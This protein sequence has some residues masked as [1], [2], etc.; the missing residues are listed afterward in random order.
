VSTDPLKRLFESADTTRG[1]SER[2]I[3]Q[4]VEHTQLLQRA[5]D[6]ARDVPFWREHQRLWRRAALISSAAVLA[7]GGA[8]TAIT[9]LRSPVTNT[10]QM[11]C[12]SQDSVHSRVIS[13]MPYSVHPL[14]A[15]KA[16]LH[17]R[18]VPSSKT[19]AGLLCVLPDGSLGGFPPS[20]KYET[21]TS[22]GLTAFNGKL[23]YPHV[24][25]F[26]KAAHSFFE[27]HACSNVALAR[28]RMLELIG[29]YALRGWT[30]QVSGSKVPTACATFDT[31]SARRI[32]DVV[33]VIE[34][35]K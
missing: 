20:K 27:I 11:S 22:I 23:K 5:Q 19:S 9:L 33:A 2:A 26:E 18:S 4:L 30:V 8:A 17:W 1:M 6:G 21:C 16:Q 34:K 15:C 12:Y 31:Q 35:S 25:A 28:R 3:D 7:V 24:F 13:E 32:I 14:G 10:S 29:K